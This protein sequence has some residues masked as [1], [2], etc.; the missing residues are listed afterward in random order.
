MA[1]PFPCITRVIAEGAKRISPER[2]QPYSWIVFS[3]AAGADYFFD[4]FIEGG[5][6]LRRLAS[7]RFAVT[8][9]ATARALEKRGIHADFMPPAF[10]GKSLALGLAEIVRKGEKILL[11]HPGNGSSETAALLEKRAVQFEE[12][13]L[14]NTAALSEGGETALKIIA[15]GRFDYVF[16]A[17]PSAVSAFAARVRQYGLKNIKALCIGESTAK[18]ASGLG[19]ISCT[20]KEASSRGLCQLALELT[21]SPQGRPGT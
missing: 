6:D 16:F 20:A 5:G 4:S 10:N 9:P 17:S 7:I 18:R 14:Y 8:G 1:I 12:M 3:S 11:I 13:E 19:M 15:E 21:A 2:V